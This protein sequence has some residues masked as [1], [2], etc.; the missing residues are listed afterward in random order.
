MTAGRDRSTPRWFAAA[1]FVVSA[2]ITAGVLWNRR[3][4]HPT[5]PTPPASSST[6]AASATPSASDAPASGDVLVWAGQ[7]GDDPHE[8]DLDTVRTY[9]LS[10]D[11]SGTREAAE[12]PGVVVLYQGRAW[13][14]T[15]VEKETAGCVCDGTPVAG[16]GVTIGADLVGVGHDDRITIVAPPDVCNADGP[17]PSVTLLSTIG[18]LLFVRSD[19]TEYGCGA[20][21]IAVP[22]FVVWDLSTGQPLDLLHSVDVT[23]ARQDAIRLLAPAPDAG[24]AAPVTDIP[25]LELVTLQPSFDTDGRLVLQGGFKT[26]A[27]H[28]CTGSTSF[29]WGDY[30]RGVLVPVRPLPAALEPFAI[31]PAAVRWFLATHPDRVVGGFSQPAPGQPVPAALRH[32]LQPARQ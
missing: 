32:E 5:A 28:A 7:S 29:T 11:A 9:L 13:R 25:D 17:S 26:W 10:T 19:H 20:H 8:Q 31:A 23:V 14:W 30:S 12:I 1:V 15:P 3:A 6:L 18:P 27:C 16:K 22:Q 2:A 4:P 21:G 24:A